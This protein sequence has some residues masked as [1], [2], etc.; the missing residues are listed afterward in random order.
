MVKNK[1]GIDIDNISAI[2]SIAD[3]RQKAKEITSRVIKRG[4]ETGEKFG[5]ILQEE[6]DKL[7]N[8]ERLGLYENTL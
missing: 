4:N 3:D 2:A 5:D 8:K 7:K 1:D 6:V